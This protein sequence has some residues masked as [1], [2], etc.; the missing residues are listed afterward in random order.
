[1]K[2]IMNFSKTMWFFSYSLVQSYPTFF[3][4]F[5]VTLNSGRPAARNLIVM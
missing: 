5:G 3:S 2:L 1:M 4:I